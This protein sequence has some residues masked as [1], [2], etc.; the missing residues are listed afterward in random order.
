MWFQVWGGV[1]RRQVYD[2]VQLERKRATMPPDY[3][4]P[5]RAPGLFASQ[6]C[7]SAPGGASVATAQLLLITSHLLAF[8]VNQKVLNYTD[9]PQAHGARGLPRRA[10]E[11]D[12]HAAERGDEAM[13]AHL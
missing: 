6:Q 9:E 13:R 3:M 11:A 7:S 8:P 2:L 12:P 4:L 10:N 1:G 5:R